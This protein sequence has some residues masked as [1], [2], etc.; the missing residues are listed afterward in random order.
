MTVAAYLDRELSRLLAL[1]F[2]EAFGRA[3]PRRAGPMDRVAA[4]VYTLPAVAFGGSR[5]MSQSAQFPCL[6]CPI[7]LT[8]PIILTFVNVAGGPTERIDWVCLNNPAHFGSFAVDPTPPPRGLSSR[9]DG[10]V[11][12]GGLGLINTQPPTRIW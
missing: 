12:S 5:A 3:F 4:G 1:D 6:I 7:D 8:F 9:A 11:A 2:N 10:T